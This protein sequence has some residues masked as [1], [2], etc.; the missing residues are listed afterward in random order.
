MREN[1]AASLAAVLK[2]EGGYVNHPRDPGGATN[3]GVTQNTYNSWRKRQGLPAQSVKNITQ[4]EVE[5][6][7]RRDYWDAVRGD[8]LPSGVDLATFDYAVNSGVGRAVRS[9]QGVLKRPQTGKITDAD[10]DA[11]RKNP[12]VWKDLCDERLGFLKRLGTWGVFGKGWGRRVADVKAK[13][14]ALAAAKPNKP[15]PPVPGIN[16]AIAQKRLTELSFPLGS[17]DGKIGSLTRSAIR[18]FQD[19]AGLPITGILDQPTYDRLLSPD[20]P[21]RPVPPER[22]ALTAEDLKKSGSKIVT[23]ADNIKSNVTTAAGALAAASGMAS[24]ATE[25]TGHVQTIHTAVTSS[26]DVFS[27]V[28]ENWQLAVIAVL[29]LVVVLCIYRIWKEAQIVETERVNA[30]RKGENV[31]V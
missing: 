22:E 17:I 25:V 7:Y 11:A 8:D 24:Q 18:D 13:S 23:S 15:V 31:R 9:L 30:A 1:Y 29:L 4:A 12:G 3:K 10:I 20:A 21:A 27:W 6:I 14:A 5:S 16:P 26:R 2:F 19:A 28:K